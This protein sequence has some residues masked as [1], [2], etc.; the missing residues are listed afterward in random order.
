M[1]MAEEAKREIEAARALDQKNGRHDYER[2]VRAD[3]LA[4]G[5]LKAIY[6]IPTGQP[7]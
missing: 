4:S 3:W 1:T 2:A 6:R 7:S 5:K